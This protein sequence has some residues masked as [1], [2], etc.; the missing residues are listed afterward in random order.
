MDT[1]FN[2][3]LFKNDFVCTIIV[4]EYKFAE[5]LFVVCCKMC[6]K[7]FVVYCKMCIKL[8]VVFVEMCIKRCCPMLLLH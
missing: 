1:L 7:L 4:L 8:L 5:K 6:I 3:D 2:A